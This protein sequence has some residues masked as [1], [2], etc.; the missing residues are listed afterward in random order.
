MLTRPQT[1]STTGASSPRRE[2]GTCRRCTARETSSA[3]VI[4]TSLGS[5]DLKTGVEML[6]D[7]QLTEN[8]G[9]SGPIYYQDLNGRP[10]QVQ[11]F[12]FG[13]FSTLR[14]EW[15]GADNRNRRAAVFLQ[16]RWAI[17]TRVT[18]TDG[19]RYDR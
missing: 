11:L 19:L 15:T 13:N 4:P 2:T 17:T 7:A 12:N 1:P 18:L 5:H 6:D 10:D 3:L 16:D 14:S 8:T 9:E